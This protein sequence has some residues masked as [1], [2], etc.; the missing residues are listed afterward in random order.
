M[1]EVQCLKIKL[2]PSEVDPMIEFLR[3]L[4]NRTKQVQETLKAEGIILETLFL[5]RTDGADYLIFYT[6][7]VD[8][9]QSAKAFQ[10]SEHPLDRELKPLIQRAWQDVR[11]LE[12]IVD[13]E[14]E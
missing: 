12:L 7:A 3:S 2:N 4:K 8:L 9:Q 11:T 6:R 1:A 5:E 13:L 14:A 10:E